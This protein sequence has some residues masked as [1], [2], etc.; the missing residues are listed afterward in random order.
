M[1]EENVL[2]ALRAGGYRLT[3]PRRKLVDLLLHA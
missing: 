1:T 2:E 3:A